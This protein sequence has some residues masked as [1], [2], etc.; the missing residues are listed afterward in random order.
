M[1]QRDNMG[2]A[3]RLLLV[4]SALVVTGCMDRTDNEKI[5]HKIEGVR[6]VNSPGLTFRKMGSGYV[7]G[8][9][10]KLGHFEVIGELASTNGSALPPNLAADVAGVVHAE[11]EKAGCV[12]RGGGHGGG[13]HYTPASEVSNANIDTACVY[14]SLNGTDG[15]VDVLVIE[16]KYAPDPKTKVVGQLMLTLNESR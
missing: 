10:E 12:I 8:T 14:Y 5:L 7:G 3:T 9:A 15:R 11:L 1:K 4:A 16:R 6:L 13:I 2:T